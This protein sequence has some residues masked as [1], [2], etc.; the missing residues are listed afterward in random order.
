MQTSHCRKAPFFRMDVDF[1]ELL[2]W[3]QEQLPITTVMRTGHHVHL[4]QCQQQWLTLSVSLRSLRIYCCIADH[5]DWL[6]SCCSVFSGEALASVKVPQTVPATHQNGLGTFLGKVP[7]RLWRGGTLPLY[8]YFTGRGEPKNFGASC[9]N[10]NVNL[11]S[12]VFTSKHFTFSYSLIVTHLVWK[13][14]AAAHICTFGVLAKTY[15]VTF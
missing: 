13:G 6:G 9:Q 11:F 3:E 12:R 8:P 2:H 14:I 15:R 7:T 10:F 1:S 5:L 4:S